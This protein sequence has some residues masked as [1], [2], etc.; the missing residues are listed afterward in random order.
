MH[1]DYVCVPTLRTSGTANFNNLTVAGNL[2][3]QG[4]T[5]TL[6]TTTCTTS[7]MSIT[8][9]GTG[10][11]LVVNQT[12][13]QP[14]VDLQD[15]GT[16]ALYIEDGGNVGIGT[17]NPVTK[18]HIAGTSEG[19]SGGLRVDH[20]ENSTSITNGYPQ[21]YI[22]NSDTTNG[23]YASIYFGDGN[24]GASG[25]ISSKIN[26]H[27]AKYGDLQFWTRGENSNGIRLHLDQ[28]GYVGI[29]TTQPNQKLHVHNGRIAVTDGYNIGDTDANTGMFVSS[30]Y[31]YIQTAGT[32][33]LQVADNG[34]VG[35]GGSPTYTLDVNGDVRAQSDLYI[36]TGGG[37]FYNDSGSRVRINQDFYTNN[38]NTYI[39]GD[40]TYLGANAANDIVHTRDNEFRT[41][42]IKAYSSCG[43]QFWD[44][45]TTEYM[46]LWDGGTVSTGDSA[47]AFQLQNDSLSKHFY[48]NHPGAYYH[49]PS[50][51]IRKDSSCTALCGIPASLVLYNNNGTCNTGTKLVFASREVAGGGNPVTTAA[52]ISRNVGGV[53]GSWA[54]GDLAI[55][56]KNR[57]T[58][59]PAMCFDRLGRSYFQQDCTDWIGS[60]T[61]LRSANE[62][63]FFDGNN[64]QNARF[65]GIQ[66]LSLIHI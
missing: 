8:N 50:M 17:T 19:T 15:D 28:E 13:I 23:N 30:D 5:T 9:A 59:C 1:T 33:R 24:S 61:Y 38:S 22:N 49:T 31:F 43:L 6:N 62:F 51:I 35:I 16:S 64:A 21:F 47:G 7:A 41:R 55:M 63:G 53:S 54:C 37:H 3:V 42:C 20:P 18:L 27:T 52:I 36:G 60:N 45:S 65:K 10:P 29:G 66:V 25:I 57:C 14:I 2:T 32:T 11:A 40:N 44:D 34:K 4:T 48:D 56:T 46:R 26:D 58:Y 39:Y 12:G